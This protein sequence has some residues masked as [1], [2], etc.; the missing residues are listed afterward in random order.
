MFGAVN[1]FLI[2]VAMK[3]FLFFGVVK[4]FTF[5]RCEYE[6][7]EI[8][9]LEDIQIECVSRSIFKWYVKIFPIVRQVACL[10]VVIFTK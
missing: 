9:K 4:S 1:S 2:F 5:W 10:H 3:S 8:Q 6:P 7:K